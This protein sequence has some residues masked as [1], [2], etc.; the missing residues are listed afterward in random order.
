MAGINDA[1]E[2]TQEL[3]RLRQKYNVVIGVWTKED[4][5]TTIMD[6]KNMDGSDADIVEAERLADI[7]WTSD[8]R[9]GLDEAVND[10][11]VF[12]DAMVREELSVHLKNH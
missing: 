10:P 3:Q 11:S 12:F 4:A 1:W 2:L 9:C 8:F 6:A 7:I 5:V